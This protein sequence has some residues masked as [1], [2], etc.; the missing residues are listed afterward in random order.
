M[1]NNR[2]KEERMVMY[3]ALWLCSLDIVSSCSYIAF[4][5]VTI[6]RW[7]TFWTNFT[8]IFCAGTDSFIF[9]V[10]NR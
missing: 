6:S 4:Q 9:L 1:I 7:A 5:Y 3:Q 2:K 8:W 10:F